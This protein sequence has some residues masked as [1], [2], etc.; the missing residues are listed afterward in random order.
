MLIIS[1]M[2]QVGFSRESFR[3]TYHV[4]YILWTSVI[5]EVWM[6]RRRKFGR[7]YR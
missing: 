6:T 7:G 3:I 5:M 2:M 1:D 4:D